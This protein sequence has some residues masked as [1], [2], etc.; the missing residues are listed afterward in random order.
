ML[1]TTCKNAKSHDPFQG[2]WWFVVSENF[3][4]ARQYQLKWHDKTVAFMICSYMQEINKITQPF[5]EILLLYYFG[6]PWQRY[7]LAKSSKTMND[8]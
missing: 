5:P 2:Y 3:G 6:E 1:T 7:A 8:P 4:Y